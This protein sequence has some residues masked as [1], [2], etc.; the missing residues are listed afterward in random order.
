[1]STDHTPP[2]HLARVYALLIETYG[3]PQWDAS[4]DPLGG[5]IGTILSQHTSDTNSGRAY[6]QLIEAFPTWE[7]VRNAPTQQVAEA[8]RVGGL[9]NI[10]APR[11]QDAL[12]TLTTWQRS[13][14]REGTLSQYL[15]EE[16]HKRTPQEAWSY[17][18]SIPGVGPK[19]AACVLMFDMAMPI[20]P[21][22]THVHRA[23]RRLGLI[24]PKVSA[25]Q[26]H[27]VFAKITPPEWIY[28][29]HVNLIRHGRQ[30][31]HA[32]RPKCG[33]CPLYMECAYVG[34]VN[35]QETATP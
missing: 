13:D 14:G 28:A 20:M 18:R 2:A 11:I 29:L 26:A 24:G 33:E 9:A 6:K 3:N 5:L 16:L 4:N 31:C 21:V 34:S 27:L 30:I 32:Q 1:M 10:K 8:I 35:E 19:T 12:H 25:D 17:L 7:Q 15:Y 22:D 23:S